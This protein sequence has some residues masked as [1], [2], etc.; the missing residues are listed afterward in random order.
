MLAVLQFVAVLSSA[1]FAGAAIYINVAEHPA[2]MGCDTKT[3]ITVWA[4]SYK[5]A[6]IMQASLAVL[7]FVSGVAIWLLSGGIMWL[8]AAAFI[9]AVIPFTFI[10]IMPTNHKLLAPDCDLDSAETRELLVKWGNL[11]AVRSVLS[12]IALVIYVALLLKA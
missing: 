5:R 3:A 11:H 9:G 12:F 7:G 6:Y 4:P 8:F 1:I 2:R 10:V